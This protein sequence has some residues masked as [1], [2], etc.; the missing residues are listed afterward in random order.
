MVLADTGHT[1]PPEA[2]Q[3]VG[4]AHQDRGD[5]RA[6]SRWC[7][8]PSSAGSRRRSASNPEVEQ[9]AANSSQNTPVAGYVGCCHGD[10]EAEHHRAPEGDQDAGARD[11]RRAGPRRPPARRA[12]SAR[13]CPGAKLVLIPQAAHIANIEQPEAFNRALDGVPFIP[14]QRASLAECTPKRSSTRATRVRD[15]VVERFRHGVERR[16]RRQ[17]DR[18]PSRSPRSCCAGARG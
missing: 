7:S 5:R 12:T 15:Q 10:L 16:H 14:C 9:I 3:A 17:D 1:Q 6:C 11:H 2:K 18:R 13:T 4:R 8:R